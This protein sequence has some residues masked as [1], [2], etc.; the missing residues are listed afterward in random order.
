[1]ADHLVQ[2]PAPMVVSIVRY[3]LGR[4]SYIVGWTVQVVI[5][6]WPGLDANTREVI[7]RDVRRALGED[8]A[9]MAM[10]AAQWR[11]LLEEVAD[12]G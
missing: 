5:G 6:V 2:V 7:V 9:G 11:H 1:M 4:A 12:R 3:A 10:D 8:R